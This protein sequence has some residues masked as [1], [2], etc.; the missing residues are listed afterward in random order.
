MLPLL[1]IIIHLCLISA[2]TSHSPIMVNGI[3]ATFFVMKW[4]EQSCYSEKF[5]NV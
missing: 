2:K 4:Q 5:G 3:Y 1:F